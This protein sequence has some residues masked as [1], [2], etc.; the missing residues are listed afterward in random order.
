V[1]TAWSYLA[2]LG[3][4]AMGGPR[5]LAQ[6]PGQAQSPAPQQ[7]L[8]SQQTTAQQTSAPQ[9]DASKQESTPLYR[10]TVVARTTKAINYRH[11]S[12]ATKID[13]H[14]TI[15][16]PFAKG[17]AKVDG[18]KSAVRIQAQFE[19]LEPATRFGPEFLTYVLWAVSPEGRADNLGEIQIEGSKSKLDVTAQ[20]QAFA[21]IVTA[22]PYFA[23]TQP[24]EVVVLENIVRPDTMGSVEEIDAKLDLLQRNQY[25][26]VQANAQ[27]IADPRVPLGLQEARNAMA[28]A[29]AAGAERY[30]ADSFQKASQLIA[31]AENYHQHKGDK[32]QLEMT[33]RE[34][35][36]TAEDARA[37][38]VKRREEER[39]AQER[40]AAA[41]REA[42]AKAMAEQAEK[43]R[44]E[45]QLAAERAAREKAEAEAA[46]LAAQAQQQAAQAEAERAR[47]AAEQAARERAEAE[48]AKSAA[49]VQQQV[50][51]VDAEKS[52]LAVA[53]AAAEKAQAEA[54]AEK[55]RKAAR[56]AEAE[57]TSLRAQLLN[58]LNSILQTQDTARGLIVNMSDVLFDTGSYTLKPGAREKLAKISGVLLSHPGLSM[59]IEGHTDSV[60]SD[61]FNQQLSER[62]SGMVRDF[63]IDQGVAASTISARGF[64]KIQPV[65]TNE[66]PEGRQRNR[67]VELVV[68]GADIDADATPNEAKFQ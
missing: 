49:Q 21:L 43:A 24:S 57:K 12:G 5:A 59:Q 13:F 25:T 54:D 19:K 14:G 35:V 47:I 22:E 65:A 55:A 29:K 67:R 11:L 36:Q 33:A 60:G 41:E 9:A 2:I 39:L 42:R 26:Y 48:L 4:L 61:E 34:A 64:G 51:Q 3:V 23:V 27:P 53:E 63:L 38:T 56:D 46:R 8:S 15:L 6:V 30:A 58:Q 20:L 7:P 62:R 50:A 44:L 32:K 18:R 37:I 45:A 68:N 1:K 52:R 17:E 10:V 31:Q 28:V 66:T 16:L 40:Q